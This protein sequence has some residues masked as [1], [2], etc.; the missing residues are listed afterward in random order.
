M[1][2]KIQQISLGLFLGCWAWGWIVIPVSA[3]LFGGSP[4]IKRIRR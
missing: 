1:S 3:I 2:N 4:V